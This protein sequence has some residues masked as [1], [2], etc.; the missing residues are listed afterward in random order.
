VVAEREDR[1]E[2]DWIRGHCG[3]QFNELAGGIATVF[4]W[5]IW[6]SVQEIQY[7][8]DFRRRYYDQ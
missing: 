5:F 8:Y 4:I 7:P 6:V 2:V 3:E 1:T